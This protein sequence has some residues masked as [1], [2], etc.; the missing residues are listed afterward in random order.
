VSI[1][2]R[3]ESSAQLDAVQAHTFTLQ[4][5]FDR[6]V[7]VPQLQPA[8]SR[9]E[10]SER[11]I[12]VRGTRAASM[13]E[14]QL[15]TLPFVVVLGEQPCTP[16]RIDSLTWESGD[17]RTRF[18]A[19]DCEIC[20]EICREGGERLFR[21]TGRLSLGQNRPNPFNAT[22][23]LEYELIETGPTELTV[24]DLMGRRVATVVS[25][26]LEAGRYIV[27]FDASGLSSGTYLYLLRTPSASIF[28][29]M[30]VVK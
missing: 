10:G 22:T 12:T 9:I 1:P 3:L 7:L 15:I 23:L 20:V 24:Q 6:S 16:V 30:E 25:G 4:L 19:A 2:L 5:R 8:A 18:G 27:P 29:L 17:V 21:T 11:I 13:S 14:G 28:K 26:T